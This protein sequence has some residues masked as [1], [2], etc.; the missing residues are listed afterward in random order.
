MLGYSK[1]LP[2]THLARSN[3][4]LFSSRRAGSVYFLCDTMGGSTLLAALLFAG[5]SAETEF[6]RKTHVAFTHH[7]D[8]AGRH[9][10]GGS[11][12]SVGHDGGMGGSKTTLWPATGTH[13]H[14]EANTHNKLSYEVY[15][16]HTFHSKES[17]PDQ[18]C[19]ASCEYN[20]DDGDMKSSIKTLHKNNHPGNP[21]HS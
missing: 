15:S 21:Y 11:A 19:P 14:N 12:H 5:A 9:S 7:S 1:H 3:F 2:R 4:F 17:T 18:H 16:E 6:D 10:Q 8:H 20:T 13:G